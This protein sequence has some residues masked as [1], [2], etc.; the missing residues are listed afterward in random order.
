L[1][2]KAV[3]CWLYRRP[4]SVA[5]RRGTQG[6]ETGNQLRISVIA[7]HGEVH[8]PTASVERLL[9]RRVPRHLE[10]RE[11]LVLRRLPSLDGLEEPV[12]LKRLSPGT[13]R[14][15]SAEVSCDPERN[16]PCFDFR[17]FLTKGCHF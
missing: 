6:D 9:A 4:R 15:L 8:H 16:E 5:A 10:Q 2:E 7:Y 1:E 3:R 11:K 12:P 17:N 14:S 13:R